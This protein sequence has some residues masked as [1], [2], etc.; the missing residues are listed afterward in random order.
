MKAC[1]SGAERRDL[2]EILDVREWCPDGPLFVDG[3]PVPQVPALRH[4]RGC[5]IDELPESRKRVAG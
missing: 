5:C 3:P 4:Q 2:R 1:L